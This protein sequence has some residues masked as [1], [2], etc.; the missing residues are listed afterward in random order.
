MKEDAAPRESER[1]MMNA[2][3]TPISRHGIRDGERKKG[4]IEKSE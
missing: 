1:E 4:A 3:R 2:E